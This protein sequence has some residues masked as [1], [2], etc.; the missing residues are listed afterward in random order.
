MD[1]H[2][3]LDAAFGRAKRARENARSLHEA[4]FYGPA[5]VW[6]VRAAEILLRDFVLAPHFVEQGHD[7]ESAMQRGSNILGNS[8]WERALAKAEEWYGP[9]DEPLTEDGGNA[10]RY[11]QGTILRRRGGIV[12]GRAVPDVSADESAEAITFAEQMATWFAL[13]FLVSSTHP[14]GQRFRELYA[15]LAEAVKDPK[16]SV[17]DHRESGVASQPHQGRKSQSRAQQASDPQSS[18]A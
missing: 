12:H 13:R 10:W 16:Q 18:D 17:N 15:K 2:Q 11:W 9:F 6:A 4:G 1:L 3:H 5:L 8:K 14:N 7:W